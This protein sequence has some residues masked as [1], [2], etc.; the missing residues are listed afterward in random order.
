[1]QKNKNLICLNGIEPVAQSGQSTSPIKPSD[2]SH[3]SSPLSISFEQLLDMPV[4]NIVKQFENQFN[5]LAKAHTF[6]TKNNGVSN[7]LTTKPNSDIPLYAETLI[8][9]LQE[10]LKNN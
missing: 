2:S 10:E 5:S 4:G 9:N 1:M 3:N 7:I 8:E 6:F